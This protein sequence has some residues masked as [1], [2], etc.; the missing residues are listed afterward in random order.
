M[1]S[2]YGD[3]CRIVQKGIHPAH[4]TS[5]S[6]LHEFDFHHHLLYF[7]DKSSFYRQWLQTVALDVARI[8]AIKFVLK[9]KYKFTE[10][11]W[12]WKMCIE[13]MPDFFEMGLQ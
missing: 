10:E 9:S 5:F 13:R 4:E 2:H 1:T 6:A 8:I 11:C 7:M 3:L 12:K